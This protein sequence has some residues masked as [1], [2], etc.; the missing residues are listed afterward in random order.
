MMD[1]NYKSNHKKEKL[2]KELQNLNS[3]RKKNI[4]LSKI[5]MNSLSMKMKF[6]FMRK[7]PHFWIF[8]LT[9]C[10]HSVVYNN[11]AG[12]S[13]NDPATP[14][15]IAYGHS[16]GE[17][18]KHRDLGS[19]QGD[20]G[21]AQI[22]F[23]ADAL[24]HGTPGEILM[25]GGVQELADDPMNGAFDM[26]QLHQRVADSINAMHDANIQRK[27]KLQ[28][29]ASLEA[30]IANE[31]A[32]QKREEIERLKNL[33]SAAEVNEHK[34][35]EVL[36]KKII[37]VVTFTQETLPLRHHIRNILRKI[38]DVQATENENIKA[39]L[40][41]A[42]L[43]DITDK[44]GTNNLLFTDAKRYQAFMKASGLSE[45]VPLELPVLGING[46]FYVSSHGTEKGH[47]QGL[48]N[49][50]AFDGHTHFE[51]HGRVGQPPDTKLQ[52]PSSV[53]VPPATDLPSP[54]P[55]FPIPRKNLGEMLDSPMSLDEINEQMAHGRD[56]AN[57]TAEMIR[58]IAFNRG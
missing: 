11:D 46:E 2:D 32:E 56:V 25:S 21:K 38:D 53:V 24:H 58:E 29:I 52:S 7:M 16:S 37:P 26:N 5:I 41:V 39:Q 48:P 15:G 9:L 44:I 36:G 33:D 23:T 20:S 17:Y 22:M 1:R 27:M 50:P 31:R 55:L 18:Y 43:D 28:E 42:R 34:K 3:I 6:K 13:H 8:F 40:E 19:H 45:T 49:P 30:E 12:L 51:D 35:P 10:T 54:K 4:Y 47:V 57:A 14:A